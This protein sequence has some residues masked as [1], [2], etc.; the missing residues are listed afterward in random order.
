MEMRPQEEHDGTPLLG[1]RDTG[2]ERTSENGQA[3]EEPDELDEFALAL[4]RGMFKNEEV[5]VGAVRDAGSILRIDVRNDPLYKKVRALDF[6]RWSN[7]GMEGKVI[8]AHL[9]AAIFEM[10]PEQVM[11]RPVP[12]INLEEA[13]RNVAKSVL[14]TAFSGR[15]FRAIRVKKAGTLMGFNVRER[16]E[17]KRIKACDNVK[18]ADVSPSSRRRLARIVGKMFAV[19][20][21]VVMGD[22]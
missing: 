16:E 12:H 7:I 9:V 20:G 6:V 11:G 3:E 14:C 19:E 13:K 18:W 10:A 15:E 8:V 21:D 1:G 2:R 4:L 17:Y 22:Y 5:W